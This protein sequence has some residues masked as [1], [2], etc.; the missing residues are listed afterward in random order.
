MAHTY[1]RGKTINSNR[2]SDRALHAT[3][4]NRELTTT[5]V[6]C[7]VVRAV[8]RYQSLGSSVNYLFYF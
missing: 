1:I 8:D 2:A 6:V 3:E 4:K 5:A 7:A